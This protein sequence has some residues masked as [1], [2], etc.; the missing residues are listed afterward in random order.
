MPTGYCTVPDVRRALQET[1][2]E[3]DS[4]AW[5]EADHA[6]VVD[7]IV[8]QTQSIQEEFDRH[9]YV[10]G[11][12][13]EDVQD[14]IPTSAKSRADEEHDIPSSP[15]AGRDQI[16]IAGSDTRYPQ[17]SH[18]PYARIRLDKHYVES[19]TA[20][21]IRDRSGDYTDWVAEPD[22][23]AGDDY[24]LYVEP[25]TA[26][27][28]SYVDIHTGTLPNL[29]HYDRAVRASYDY[30]T[31]TLSRTIR[32]AVAFLAGS[33]LLLDYQAN[34]GIPEQSQLVSVESKKQAMES[35]ADDLLDTYR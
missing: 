17:R 10:S 31:D 21:K 9:W 35:K 24:D 19:L 18:G 12:L 25:G 32:R 11:G 15:H 26:S 8:G 27:G 1:M 23:T 13:G 30:G 3:F 33:E 2:A 22:Y 28:P 14:L 29:S 34:L 7:A 6:V 20:L 16:H 4:G 5:G